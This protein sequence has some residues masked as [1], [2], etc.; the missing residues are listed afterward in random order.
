METETVEMEG[1][2]V[3]EGSRPE[4]KGEWLKEGIVYFFPMMKACCKSAL[5]N[6]TYSQGISSDIL[7]SW[8]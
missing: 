1:E 7:R 4:E 2:R 5:N 3:K 6:R 8:Y